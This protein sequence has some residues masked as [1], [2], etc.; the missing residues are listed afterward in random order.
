[1]YR[2]HLFL[3]LGDLNCDVTVLAGLT[4]TLYWY[5]NNVGLYQSDLICE[6]TVSAELTSYTLLVQK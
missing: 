2:N 3:S 1:M 5:R 4:S 6:V